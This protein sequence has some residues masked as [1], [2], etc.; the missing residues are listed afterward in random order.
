M[1]GSAH[2]WT[3]PLAH[4]DPGREDRAA[5]HEAES[6][7]RL[8]RPR[9]LEEGNLG[10]AERAR[11]GLVQ[12]VGRRGP[13]PVRPSWLP[14]AR[15][16]RSSAQRP[17]G[18]EE[19]RAREAS[20]STSGRRGSPMSKMYRGEYATVSGIRESG[21]PTHLRRPAVFRFRDTPLFLAACL[22]RGF[23]AALAVRRLVRFAAG[24]FAFFAFFWE[25]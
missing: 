21:A 7:D 18:I 4:R 15:R 6:F 16:N 19:Y 11:P 3:L 23:G 9:Q 5:G 12:V 10:R 20:T 24:A 1:T 14:A 13:T 17:A 8:G 22:A 25:A 2:G